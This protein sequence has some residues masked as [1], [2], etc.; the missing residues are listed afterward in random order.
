[1]FAS[2]PAEHSLPLSRYPGRGQ[3]EG[4][5]AR[6]RNLTWAQHPHPNPL[7]DYREREKRRGFT[8]IE[9]LVVI[10]IILILIGMF[11]VGMHV[12]G[13]HTKGSAA[14]VNLQNLQGMLSEL[15]TT[16]SL[17]SRQPVQMWVNGALYPATPGDPT[18]PI[19]IWADA[20]PDTTPPNPPIVTGVNDPLDAPG[21]VSIEQWDGSQST[22]PLSSH[23][24]DRFQSE[25]V[26]NTQ[27]VMQLLLQ[28]PNNR[29]AIAK[30]GQE[31][32]LKNPEQGH[33]T[34]GHEIVT[35]AGPNLMLADPVTGGPKPALPKP[36]LA[37][38]AI[39]PPVPVDTWGNPIIL[40]P[41]AGLN[42]ATTYSA[43]EAYK[44]GRI[45][46]QAAGAGPYYRALKSIQGAPPTDKNSWEQLP[47]GYNP[48]FTSPDRRPFFCSAGNDGDFRT[49]DDNVYS[50]E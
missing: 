8:L 42:V 41:A 43:A 47:A 32:L 45:V 26:C 11:F 18:K 10:G 31:A 33:A 50:F 27:L 30:L 19:N 14:K 6:A 9:I 39:T 2:R 28:V 46:S 21:D 4:F 22:D 40:V 5:V 20:R 15:E 29:Q 17:R 38:G 35:N 49:P 12:I 25:A 36:A 1:M 24:R 44:P 23:K 37:N 7:P 3:G 16:G 13:R 48:V 34:V